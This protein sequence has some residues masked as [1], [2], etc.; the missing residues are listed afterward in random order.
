MRIT[1]QRHWLTSKVEGKQDLLVVYGEYTGKEIKS[2]LDMAYYGR[3]Y[4]YLYDDV[5]FLTYDIEEWQIA[6]YGKEVIKNDYENNQ[7]HQGNRC[8]VFLS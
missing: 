2:M 8:V 4:E 6:K 7:V 5:R 3:E 1:V